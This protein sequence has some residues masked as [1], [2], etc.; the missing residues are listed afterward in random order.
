MLKHRRGLLRAV[1]CDRSLILVPGPLVPLT[2]L[3]PY[4]PQADCKCWFCFDSQLHVSQHRLG[5]IAARKFLFFFLPYCL[6]LNGPHSF[7]FQSP[8]FAFFLFSSSSILFFSPFPIFTPFPSIASFFHL[9]LGNKCPACIKHC[10]QWAGNVWIGIFFPHRGVSSFY[11]LFSVE[12]PASNHSPLSG[13]MCQGDSKR[14]SQQI[15]THL[16]NRATTHL[17]T[18]QHEPPKVCRHFNWTSH[19]PHPSFRRTHP[20]SLT[21]KPTLLSTHTSQGWEGRMYTRLSIS[22]FFKL[23]FFFRRR[24]MDLCENVCNSG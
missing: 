12:E 2:A 14:P 21:P 8:V 20:H 5:P 1:T 6:P 19:Q 16:F 10:K 18:K 7:S 4:S 17:F 15:D 13:P 9:S 11:Y 24:R 23:A 22:P 3:Y